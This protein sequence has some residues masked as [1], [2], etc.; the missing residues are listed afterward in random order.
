[1][2]PDI[3]D[4]EIK[5]FIKIMFIYRALEKGWTVSRGKRSNSF[6]FTRSLNYPPNNPSGFDD[7]YSCL[8]PRRSISEPI[9]HN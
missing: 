3:K 9:I 2:N 6:E 7:S 5:E 8:G 4:H 1:M